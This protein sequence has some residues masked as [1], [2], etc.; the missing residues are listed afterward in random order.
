M[1]QE[2]KRKIFHIGSGTVLAVLYYY[3]LINKTV[4]AILLALGIIVYFAYKKY[5]LPIIHQLVQAMERKDKTKQAGLTSILFLLGCTTTVFIFSKQTA[6]AAI[7]ILAWGDS[8]SH[9]VG[10]KGNIPYINPKKTWE[11]IIAGT[12]TG[13]IAAQF[14][15]PWLNALAGAGVSMLIEGLDLEIFGW[16]IDDNLLIPIIAGIVITILS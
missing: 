14:L 5:K 16:K 3:G 15:V 1:N 2:L 13:T 9:M 8:I 11:G 7:L 10:I 4:F 6:T 12:I